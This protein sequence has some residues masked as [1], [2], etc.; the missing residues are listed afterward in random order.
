MNFD[1]TAIQ[2]GRMNAQAA[3]ET[4]NSFA[5]SNGSDLVNPTNDLA[6]SPRRMAGQMGARAM[7]LMTDPAE[8]KR[9]QSWM[10]Q[11]GLSNEGVQFNQA[12][13][14]GGMPPQEQPQ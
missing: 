6:R 3:E 13:M 5:E 7:A 12:K 2:Q 1:K 11:F 14:M 8:Q 10:Q 9:T 4:P